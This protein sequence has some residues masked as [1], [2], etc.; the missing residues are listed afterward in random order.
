MSAATARRVTSLCAPAGYGKSVLLADWSSTGIEADRLA[1]LRLD[2]TDNIDSRFCVALAHAL[3]RGGAVGEDVTDTALQ[4]STPLRDTDLIDF[5]GGLLESVSRT[6]R[7]VIL[8]LDDAHLLTHPRILRALDYILEFAPR[9]LHLVMAHRVEPPLRLPRIRLAGELTTI[10]VD[11]LAFT[12]EETARL[13]ESRR[14][15]LDADQLAAV[16]A[17]TRGWGA[18][19]A[20]AALWLDSPTGTP[21]GLVAALGSGSVTADY[22]NTE[23]LSVLPAPRR[24]M[25]S[26]L[27]VADELTADLAAVLASG[28]QSGEQVACL[29]QVSPFLTPTGQAGV[30][31]R[32]HPLVSA[33]LRHDLAG[34]DRSGVAELHRTAALWFS[35]HD[36]QRSAIHHANLT[37]D[38]R[39]LAE[40]IAEH[41]LELT[42][43][44]LRDEVNVALAT[45]PH[46][47]RSEYPELSIAQAAVHISD[48]A[49]STA[50]PLVEGTLAR[51]EQVP[52]RRRPLVAAM[53]AGI[54]LYCSQLGTPPTDVRDAVLA[55]LRGPA[56]DDM[57]ASSAEAARRFLSLAL[58]VSDQRT[59][60]TTSFADVRHLVGD[61]LSTGS[62]TSAL[63]AHARLSAL[64]CY[65]GALD[66]AA[67]QA[68]EAIDES[69]RQ[70]LDQSPSVGIASH[71]LAWVE[72]LRGDTEAAHEQARRAASALAGRDTVEHCRVLRLT[73]LLLISEWSLDEARTVLHEAYALWATGPAPASARTDQTLLITE[74]D[75]LLAEGDYLEALRLAGDPDR[76]SA[77]SIYRPSLVIAADA[78]LR[79]DNP[80][81]VLPILSP[82]LERRDIGLPTQ[83]SVHALQAAAEIALGRGQAAMASLSAAVGLAAHT[84]I[85][86]P[87]LDNHHRLREPLTELADADLPESE[88]LRHLLTGAE[89]EP[90]TRR[91]PAWLPQPLTPREQDILRY[92]RSRLSLV[93]IAAI[94]QLSPNTVK[95]HVKHIYEKL[96]VTGRREAVQRAT[97][98][99]LL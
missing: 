44:E 28:E 19:I 73:S 49:L 35:D 67:E 89:P 27:A 21:A 31:Y 69:R 96:Q 93:E 85:V 90:V 76:L 59:G 17:L 52:A 97:D 37:G 1:W 78:H 29:H 16:H 3:Q 12:L 36:R 95:T 18:G 99:N 56:L 45:L 77:T 9:T 22:L 92:L 30:W 24:R 87:L 8:V 34:R 6:H 47:I 33:A 43:A 53:A 83:I 41:W 38:H 82:W 61:P 39:F 74:A 7:R 54:R 72:F 91:Q 15:P 46:E 40:L 14:V 25:L 51:L 62:F 68:R 58:T 94:L 81:A 11:D 57:P 50:L 20:L 32:W 79:M 60:P 88:F 26:R 48:G 55:A 65:V 2:A 84:G 71:T 5:A 66:S 42:G 98:L 10:G 86:R 64:T 23:V 63:D 80:R 75:L 13:L 70:N 4:L